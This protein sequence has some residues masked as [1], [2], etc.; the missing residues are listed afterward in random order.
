MPS[1]AHTKKADF[2]LPKIDDRRQNPMTGFEPRFIMPLQWLDCPVHEGQFSYD[3]DRQE[4][5]LGE[6]W[7][8]GAGG[9][10]VRGME[11]FQTCSHTNIYIYYII[12]Y[13]ILLYYIILYIIYIYQSHIYIHILYIILCIYIRV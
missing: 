11:G 8:T 4:I 6:C 5:F 7:G 12:L 10:D 3:H 1:L 2:L 9:E 13:Y